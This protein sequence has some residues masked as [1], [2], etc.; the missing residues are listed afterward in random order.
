MPLPAVIVPPSP[1]TVS[2][3]NVAALTKVEDATRIVAEAASAGSEDAIWGFIRD[4][5]LVFWNSSAHE[6]EEMA[7]LHGQTENG[8]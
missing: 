2:Q 7:Q 1:L 4:F 6:T 3:V 5:G 8:A